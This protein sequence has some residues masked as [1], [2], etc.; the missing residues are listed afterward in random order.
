MPKKAFISGITGMDGSHLADLLLE[1]D[2][3]VYGLVRRSSAPNYWRIAHILDRI[4]LVEGD[5]LDQLSLDMAI[6]Y[7]QPDEIYSLGAQS[8]VHVSWG[9][10]VLTAEITGLGPLRLLDAMRKFKPDA[11]FFQ[12]S[13]SEMFGK[14]RETPQTEHTPFYPRS[15]YGCAKL[16]AHWVTI[17][18]RESYNLFACAGISF[19]HESERRGEEF[20]TRKITQAVARIAL[21][22]EEKLRLG[23]L[24]AKRDWGYAPDYVKG[25]WRMLQEDVVGEFVFATGE[26]HSVREF[27][28]AAFAYVGLGWS[29][30]VEIDPALVRPAEVDLLLGNPTRARMLLGWRP[31]VKFTELVKIMVDADILRVRRAKGEEK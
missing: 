22:S 20:V 5:L 28:E 1:K 3:K 13:S 30:R 25:Y 15:P 8:H 26:T 6:R 29:G 11:R 9:Q 24:D 21:G 14:V 7:V 19:N 16:F 18:Y 12:A 17:N 31:T 4:T 10:P 27:V 2:Y 23:N